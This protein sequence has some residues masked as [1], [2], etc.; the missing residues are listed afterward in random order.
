M[1]ELLVD[2][3]ERSVVLITAR[4]GPE[5]GEPCAETFGL[6]PRTGHGDLSAVLSAGR[7]ERGRGHCMELR[8]AGAAGSVKVGSPS[9]LG[10]QRISVIT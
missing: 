5:R 6:E 1:P 8:A 10:A 2:V 3:V 9:L 7:A 4:P